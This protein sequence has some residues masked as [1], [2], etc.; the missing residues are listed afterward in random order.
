MSSSP[1]RR[2]CGRYAT[3][4]T[5]AA[6]CDDA[7]RPHG[8]T[9]NSF[10]SVSLVPPL[11]LFCVSHTTGVWEHFQRAEWVG[12][13]VLEQGQREIAERFSRR[14]ADRF[15]GIEWRRGATSGAPLIDRALATFECRIARRIVA[16][17][18]DILIAE[19]THTEAHY[20]VPLVYFEGG[21]TVL[22]D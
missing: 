15:A 10:T 22:A 5:I 21:Y 9:V 12:I 3:G 18:H 17:D 7:G 6:V 13:S 1:F 8:L 19:A 14:H 20:G 16:G 11:V 2:A 4:V